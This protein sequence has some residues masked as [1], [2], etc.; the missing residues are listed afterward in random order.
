M[1][2]LT[3]IDVRAEALGVRRVRIRVVYQN[4]EVSSRLPYR[5]RN[6]VLFTKFP[7]GRVSVGFAGGRT[8]VA[9]RGNACPLA[10]WNDPAVVEMPEASRRVLEIR[11]ALAEFRNE[12]RKRRTA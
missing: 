4:P 12:L 10:N 8:V 11:E 9:L 2:K 3:L 7:S 1:K 6:G 5:A